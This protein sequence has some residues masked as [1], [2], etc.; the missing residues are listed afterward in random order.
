MRLIRPGDAPPPDRGRGIAHPYKKHEWFREWLANKGRYVLLTCGHKED[1]NFR[2][3]L[4]IMAVFKEIDVFCDRC[5]K[6]ATI[7]SKI[8]F[9]EYA[10]VPPLK[11]SD[12]PLF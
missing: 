8:S 7:K 2:G 10:E 11:E 12:E 6:W 1:I 5:N 3:I 9:M 4:I